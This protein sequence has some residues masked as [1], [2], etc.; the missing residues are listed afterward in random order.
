MRGTVS[1]AGK[2]A[3]SEADRETRR[4]GAFRRDGADGRLAGGTARRAP[5]PRAAAGGAGRSPPGA[6]GSD[7]GLSPAGPTAFALGRPAHDA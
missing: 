3:A 7:G 1:R 5:R 4:R 6:D 2:T